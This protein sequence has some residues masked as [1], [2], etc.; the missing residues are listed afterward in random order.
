ME[1]TAIFCK[2]KY[3]YTDTNVTVDAKTLHVIAKDPGEPVPFTQE[4]KIFDLDRFEHDWSLAK[5]PRVTGWLDQNPPHRPIIEWW[6]ITSNPSP[7]S[8]LAAGLS[9]DIP[10]L[11]LKDPKVLANVFQRAHQMLFAGFARATF[12][13]SEDANRKTLQGYR[14]VSSLA[15]IVVEVFARLLEGFL[16]MVA[17]CFAILGVL[18]FSRHANLFS[19]PDS[20]AATMA[21]VADSKALLR[22]FDGLGEVP[23]LKKNLLDRTYRL[24][25]WDSNG[26]YR[27]DLEETFDNRSTSSKSDSGTFFPLN[28]SRDTR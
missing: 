25:K 7:I 16:G 17:I 2:P 28:S 26:Y 3:F 8:T 14:T 6:N 11:D 1:L 23:K 22:D 10:F 27:I 18:I 9:Q 12:Q 13:I 21:L 15:I 24:D 19:D 20:L 5:A 4:D